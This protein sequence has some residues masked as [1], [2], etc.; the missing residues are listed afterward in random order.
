LINHSIEVA[1]LK[2]WFDEGELVYVLAEIFDEENPDCILWFA[3][4]KSVSKDV[5][6]INSESVN[7]ISRGETLRFPHFV[8]E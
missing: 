5:L 4:M 7:I 2:V 8:F 6:R 3:I 1:G